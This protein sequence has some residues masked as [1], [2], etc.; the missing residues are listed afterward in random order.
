[1]CIKQNR[2][3]GQE[4]GQKWS[5]CDSNHCSLGMPVLCPLSCDAGVLI[6]LWKWFH[7]LV[8]DCYLGL[9]RLCR[10]EQAPAHSWV[11]RCF[12]HEHIFLCPALALFR[13]THFWWMSACWVL[14]WRGLCGRTS[15]LLWV[16]L[17]A[18]CLALLNI[19][20]FYILFTRNTHFD[21]VYSSTQY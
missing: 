9:W 20:I 11:V 13:W 2:K 1:M 4:L 12:G 3:Q 16:V 15:L 10:P 7:M 19:W 6:S 17:L 14:G 8:K 18:G 5:S 21:I